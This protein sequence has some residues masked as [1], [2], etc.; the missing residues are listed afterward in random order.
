M[1]PGDVRSIKDTVTSTRDK[2]S[3][4]SSLEQVTKDVADDFYISVK[5]G[6]L[7]KEG[8]VPKHD[9]S[10]GWGGMDRKYL[11][12]VLLMT[13]IQAQAQRELE[14]EYRKAAEGVKRGVRHNP[15]ALLS[16]ESVKAQT[17][18]AR[19]MQ[20]QMSRYGNIHGLG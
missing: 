4:V 15:G 16:K 11:L 9:M 10:Q 2:R 20:E 12:E 14:E 1:L 19:A 3:Y 8:F 6:N 7:L 5:L 17:D 13:D 18:R